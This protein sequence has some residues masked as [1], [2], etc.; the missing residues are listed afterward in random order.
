MTQASITTLSNH[1]KTLKVY[2]SGDTR[3]FFKLYSAYP[4]VIV[5]QL[6]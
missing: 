6:Y 4:V 2:P 3:E 5:Y 1:N